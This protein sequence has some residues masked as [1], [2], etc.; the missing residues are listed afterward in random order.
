VKKLLI[1][2][3]SKCN[4]KACLLVYHSSPNYVLDVVPLFFSGGLDILS[5]S[6]DTCDKS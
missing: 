2:G 6:G 1:L 5:Q 3:G 4:F